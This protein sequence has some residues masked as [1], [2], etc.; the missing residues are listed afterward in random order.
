MKKI[1]FER[2]HAKEDQR[3]RDTQ[4][5]WWSAYVW[6]FGLHVYNKGDGWRWKIN[7]LTETL[8]G[9]VWNTR[10]RAEEECQALLFGSLYK[11]LE[12][13]DYL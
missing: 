2:N 3:P 5:E 4:L 6:N 1:K 9:N 8:S 13:F 12:Q 7:S 11:I 10:E